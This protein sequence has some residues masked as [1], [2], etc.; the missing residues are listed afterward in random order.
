MDFKDQYIR[1][2]LRIISGTILLVYLYDIAFNK[3][4]NG[5]IYLDV[6]DGIVITGCVGMLLAIEAV[7][8]YVRRKFEGNNITAQSKSNSQ[9]EDGGGGVIPKKGF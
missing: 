2:F 1:N 6:N 4:K 8:A 7:R 3:I 5:K 9:T